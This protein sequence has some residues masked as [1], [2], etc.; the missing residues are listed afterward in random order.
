MHVQGPITKPLF[1]KAILTPSYKHQVGYIIFFLEED[2]LY[3][4]NDLILL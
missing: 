4:L 2:F 1:T 3:K